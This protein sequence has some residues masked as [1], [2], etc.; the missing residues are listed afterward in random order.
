MM[1]QH[2]DHGSVQRLA[3]LRWT[4]ALATLALVLEG[5]AVES[6]FTASLSGGRR[7]CQQ[8]QAD[9]DACATNSNGTSIDAE[10]AVTVTAAK[11]DDNS[12]DVGIPPTSLSIIEGKLA[13]ETIQFD[14]EPADELTFSICS[15]AG[16]STSPGSQRAGSRA[17]NPLSTT[18]GK[19]PMGSTPG[20]GRD[21]LRAPHAT[22]VRISRPPAR[23]SPPRPPFPVSWRHPAC[24]GSCRPRF[25]SSPV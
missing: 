2:S 24:S 3:L 11:G 25:G 8:I 5:L 21:T 17:R 6:A 10:R 12:G 9:L 15:S 18:H 16:V 13:S 20:W 19:G 7:P 14:T 22:S 1:S 23:F 4:E